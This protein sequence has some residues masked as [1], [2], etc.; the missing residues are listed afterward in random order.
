MKTLSIED[1]QAWLAHLPFTLNENFYPRWPEDVGFRSLY[2]ITDHYPSSYPELCRRILDWLPAGRDRLLVVGNWVDYPQD[3]RLIFEAIR[4]ISEET[5]S[6]ALAPGHLFTS[7]KDESTWYDD[8]LTIDVVEE[9]I[10]MWLT[11]LMLQ[12]EWNGTAFVQDCQDAVYF[13]DGYIEFVSLDDRRL[14]QAKALA[15]EHRVATTA[16]FPWGN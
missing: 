1:C 10:A 9:A 5:E 3:H 2:V 16:T 13:G 4:N 14:D 6:L 8:R 12:W 11:A 15:Q 7:T